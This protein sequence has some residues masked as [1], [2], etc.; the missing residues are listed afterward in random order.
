[1]NPLTP[2][3]PFPL[4]PGWYV[5]VGGLSPADKGMSQPG[6]RKGVMECATLTSLFY[7]AV[8]VLP[9]GE[10]ERQLPAIWSGHA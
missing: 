3:P 1:V 7:F 2:P 5:H 6:D 10:G 9:D 4:N 8:D